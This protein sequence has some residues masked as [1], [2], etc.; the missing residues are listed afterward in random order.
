MGFYSVAVVSVLFGLACLVK[1]EVVVKVQWGERGT[2]MMRGMSDQARQS[3]EYVI[4][5]LGLAALIIG[6]VWVSVGLQSLPASSYIVLACVQ[7]LTAAFV[8]QAA[9][10]GTACFGKDG[11]NQPFYAVLMAVFSVA[12][13]LA[14][15]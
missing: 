6:G 14:A 3:F 9:L 7:L 8:G 1:P 5:I 2:E 13:F 4:R 15:M 11:G 10:A 12:N